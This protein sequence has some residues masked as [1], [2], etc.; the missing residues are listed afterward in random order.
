MKKNYSLSNIGYF[1]VIKM[2]NMKI[3]NYI[4]QVFSSIRYKSKRRGDKYPEFTKEDLRNW[5]YENRLQEKWIEYLESGCD[6]N[7]K[8]SI[9]RIDDYGIYEF[10][11]M[12]LI[13]WKEN[14]LKGVNGKK[15]H[16]NS[17]NQNLTKAVF[18]WN[19][20]GE[21]VKE[22]KCYRDAADFLDCHLVSISRATTG[23]RKTI[24]KH[25]LTNYKTYTSH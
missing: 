15:H 21:L 10:S 1:C 22:C 19:K 11:N 23:K 5:L 18:V 8:P 3:E 17:K 14:L 13:T 20:K 16:N 9:D 2:V 6:K 25:I 7:K 24:K 12:Q 4:T